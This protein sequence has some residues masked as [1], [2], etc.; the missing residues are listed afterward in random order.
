MN[1]NEKLNR[2]KLLFESQKLILSNM[3]IENMFDS[4]EEIK[5]LELQKEIIKAIPSN[6]I[7]EIA[8]EFSV[9]GR[10]IS[11]NFKVNQKSH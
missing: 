3:T 8:K 2:I 1:T 11:E 9:L 7:K 10:T 4:L 5:S 6:Q